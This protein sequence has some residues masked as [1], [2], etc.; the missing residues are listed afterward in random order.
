MTLSCRAR[1]QILRAIVQY[2]DF[3]IVKA[4][5]VASPGF[6]KDAFLKYMNE[7]AHKQGLR[8]LLDNKGKFVPCH[9][10]S[11]NNVG[12]LL[13]VD[14]MIPR[15]ILNDLLREIS[16]FAGYCSGIS[17]KITDVCH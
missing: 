15:M 3:T 5:L 16:V 13:K 17:C 12:L 8:V 6:F 7:Q 4:V 2:I 1:W 10:S 11:G 14:C 9:A